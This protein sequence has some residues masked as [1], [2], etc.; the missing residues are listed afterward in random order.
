M[1]FGGITIAIFFLDTSG[2]ARRLDEADAE[3]GFGRRGF[4]PQELIGWWAVGGEPAPMP[5]GV[6]MRLAAV[7]D[8]VLQM[9]YHLEA[10]YDNSEKNPYNPHQPPQNV[11]LGEQTSDEMCLGGIGCVVDNARDLSK[12][13][14]FR[15]RRLRADT[16]KQP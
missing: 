14:P 11:Y 1:R 2:R 4:V 6:G 12:L 13:Q 8:L 5:E 15:V 7:S 16:A 9:H 3:P 10:H